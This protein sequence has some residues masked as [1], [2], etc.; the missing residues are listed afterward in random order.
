MSKA[1]ATRSMAAHGRHAEDG[2]AGK[3]RDMISVLPSACAGTAATVG[4]V[5][6]VAAGPAASVVAG[7]L[8]AL[9]AAL[10]GCL[11]QLS[12]SVEASHLR[13]LAIMETRIERGKAPTRMRRK[14]EGTVG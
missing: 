10:F 7:A 5:A 14:D 1:K 8:S 2:G 4:G 12:L 11:G 9:A 6:C 3:A 13:S